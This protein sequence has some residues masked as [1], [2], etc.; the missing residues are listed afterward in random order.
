MQARN[1]PQASLLPDQ[2]TACVFALG[3]MLSAPIA[4]GETAATI[5]TETCQACHAAL[6][7]KK[8]V[9]PAMS[10]ATCADCH[11]PADRPGKCKSPLAKGWKLKDEENKLCRDCHTGIGTANVHPII[12]SV[13]CTA[14]HDPHSSDNDTLLKTAPI[15]DL[16]QTCHDGVADFPFAH[17]PVKLGK[18]TE[19]H[20]PHASPN[21]PLLKVKQGALCLK[22]HTTDKLLPDRFR[23]APVSDGDCAQCHAAHGSKF[24]KNTLAEAGDLCMKCHDSKA[25]TGMR[26]PRGVARIDLKK[27]TVHPAIDAGGCVGCHVS[28]HS[29]PIPKLLKKK[30]VELCYEC[31]SRQDESAFVHSA[32]KLGDCAVC[33]DPHSSDLPGLLRKEKPADTCFLC[34]A[35][36]VTGREVVHKPVADGRCTA[37]HAPHGAPNE[38][39]LTRGSGKIACYACHKPVDG[40]KNKHAVLERSGC[41]ACHDPHATNNPFLLPKPINALCQTCHPQILD[42]THVSNFIAKGHKIAGGP[43]PRNIDRDFSCASCHNPHGSD[44][45]KLLRYGEGTMESCDWCHGDRMGKHPE[46]KDISKRKRTDKNVAEYRTSVPSSLLGP[47]KPVAKSPPAPCDAGVPDAPAASPPDAP[48]AAPDAAAAAPGAID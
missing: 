14:C 39:S 48:A 15:A 13:G 33:H 18:C 21:K 8:Q 47:P 34:H 7:E 37:C 12:D 19:C 44:S 29:S 45:P 41:V 43:D 25:P 36:D 9:H 5:D 17:T 32:V 28:G 3:L 26:T 23:H 42:G 1:P 10:V 27:Q 30:P 4:R 6:T 24:P 16:C 46:M 38:F 31:H 11:V 20:D 2:L 40:G 35:D 22:C